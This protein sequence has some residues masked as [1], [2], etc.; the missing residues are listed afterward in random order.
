MAL[1]MI[2]EEQELA[3]VQDGEAIV[4]VE[5]PKPLIMDET[6]TVLWDGTKYECVAFEVED[7]IV[8]IGNEII[9]GGGVDNGIPFTVMYAPA[10]TYSEIPCFVLGSIYDTAD[11]THTVGIYQEVADEEPEEPPEPEGIVLKD[12]N[13]NDVA[14]YGIETVTFDTTT[15]GKQ[16]TFT[17]GEAVE[18]LEIEPDFSGGDMAVVAPDGKLV[19]SATVKKPEALVPENIR[20]GENVAGVVGSA[21]VPV[22]ETA[23]VELDLA[24]GDQTVVPSATDKVLTEVV[25]RKPETLVPENIAEGVTIAGIGPGTHSGGGGLELDEEPWLDDVCF[26]DV[27]GTLILNVP[28]DQLAQLTALPAPPSR[29]GLTFQ[30]WNYTLEQIKATEYPLDVG[31]LYIPTDGNTH[32]YLNVTNSSS[33]AM[34]FLFAQTV[35]NGVS[36]NWGDGTAATTVSGTGVVKATHTYSAIGQY[37]VVFTVA[38]GCVMTLGDATNSLCFIGG[39]SSSYTY[40]NYG[41]KL[42]IGNRVAIGAYG[43][44]GGTNLAMVTIPRSAHITE[45]PDYG[46]SSLAVNAMIIPD[47]VVSIGKGACGYYNQKTFMAVCIPE[48]VTSVGTN[49]INTMQYAARAV[50]PRYITALPD[51][52]LYNL[53]SVKRVFMPNS[54][55]S[56]GSR[57]LYSAYRLTSVKL[58]ERLETLGDYC[59]SSCYCLSSIR[60]P[61]SVKTIGN[62]VLSSCPVLDLY[63]PDNVQTVGSSFG[64]SPRRLTVAGTTTFSA[65]ANN[66]AS[67]KEIIHLTK[68]VPTV[69]HTSAYKF[70]CVWVPDTALAAYKAVYETSTS[71]ARVYALSEYR[72]KLPKYE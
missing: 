57:I 43:V 17:K 72:G 33:R 34:F 59:L 65:S 48:S 23:E 49:F 39:S 12:R 30:G 54:I 13:G 66:G 50:V 35:S 11:A 52:G 44:N 3:F 25:I 70:F 41:I 5:A 6:Y 58:P 69:V 62:N 9:L 56:F 10:G 40:R 16:Q 60:I 55:T 24:A 53:Y 26:W 61:P 71:Y 2:L 14:Y 20:E 15:E 29:S 22:L 51:Y 18:G 7:G 42:H 4:V 67:L 47:S 19:K 45:I 63:V 32:V 8:A 28:M 1:V 37:E 31:A 21:F 36:I 27:D 68:Q 46:V 64:G 38:D